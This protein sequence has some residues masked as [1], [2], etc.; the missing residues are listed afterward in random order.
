M[1]QSNL[2]MCAF[3]EFASIVCSFMIYLA[4]KLHDPHVKG[5]IW[6]HISFGYSLQFLFHEIYILFAAMFSQICYIIW[7]LL[8]ACLYVGYL[9]IT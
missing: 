2:Q 3:S 1:D 4:S 6:G 9:D 7:H 5:M 8:E